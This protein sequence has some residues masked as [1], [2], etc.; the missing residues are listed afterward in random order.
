MNFGDAITSLKDGKR[1]A[2]TGWNGK[3]MWLTVV[4][5]VYPLQT[6]IGQ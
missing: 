6:G 2:R 5:R 3:D 4:T 1:V